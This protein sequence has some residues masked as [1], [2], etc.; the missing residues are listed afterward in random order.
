V[1]VEIIGFSTPVSAMSFF[2]VNFSFAS[3][4][5]HSGKCNFVVGVG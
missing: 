3:L 5:E 2:E 1:G 4:V